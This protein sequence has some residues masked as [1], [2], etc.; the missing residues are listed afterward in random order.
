MTARPPP[1]RPH[2]GLN[3]SHRFSSYAVPDWAEDDAWDSGSDSE[4]PTNPSWNRTSSRRG[5]STATAPKPVPRPKLNTSS[6]TL[7]FSYTHVNHP[8]PSSYPT[9]QEIPPPKNG[10][11]IVRK[12]SDQRTS[13]DGRETDRADEG[14]AY[15]DVE[16]DMVVGDLEP[17]LVPPATI[18]HTKPRQDQG[19]VRDDAQE[20]VDG[21]HE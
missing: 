16:G 4:S 18:P 2:I 5:S 14:G 6:S 7:A 3:P 8:S 10:W 1:T 17:E 21:T 9:K 20:I 15:D 12:S 13:V 11:T 19:S